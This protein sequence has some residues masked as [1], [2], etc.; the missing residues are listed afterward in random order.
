MASQQVQSVANAL[1]QA[2]EAQAGAKPQ[3]EGLNVNWL[4]VAEAMVSYG[5][6]RLSGGTG[7][8]QALFDAIKK[9][10]NK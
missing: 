3:A 1:R 4:C 6:C 10:H 2:A 9:C 8:E 5:A 7:C